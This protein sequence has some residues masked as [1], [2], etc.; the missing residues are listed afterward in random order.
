MT[1]KK[2]KPE[3]KTKS[4][5]TEKISPGAKVIKLKRKRVFNDDNDSEPSL[6]EIRNTK[7]PLLD[8]DEDDGVPEGYGGGW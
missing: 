1:H 5:T 4:K 2:I 7:F 3:Q 6:E 8:T